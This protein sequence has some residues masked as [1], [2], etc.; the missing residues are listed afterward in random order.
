M[1]MSCELQ[2]FTDRKEHN[3]ITV[4]VAEFDP[5]ENDRRSWVAVHIGPLCVMTDNPDLLNEIAEQCARSAARLRAA[6]LADAARR[7]AFAKSLAEAK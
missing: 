3:P 1:S 7:E 2:S 5:A 4:R 6:L